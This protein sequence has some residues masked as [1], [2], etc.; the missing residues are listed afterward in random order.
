MT[1]GRPPQALRCWEFR[2][3]FYWHQRELCLHSMSNTVSI[4]TFINPGARPVRAST[5]FSGG[6][7][8]DYRVLLEWGSI[9]LGSSMAKSSGDDCEQCHT[10]VVGMSQRGCPISLL[11]SFTGSASQSKNPSTANAALALDWLEFLRRAC[12]A[13]QNTSHHNFVAVFVSITSTTFTFMSQYVMFAELYGHK[14]EQKLL[15]YVFSREPWETCGDFFYG[16]EVEKKKT[17]ATRFNQAQAW[18]VLLFVSRLPGHLLVL[19][20]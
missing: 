10:Y 16:Q 13:N 9:Q 3:A 4:N 20:K 8:T 11:W 15:V 2:F 6:A 5:L 17:F 12:G 7:A 18:N 19:S 14:M 1:Q